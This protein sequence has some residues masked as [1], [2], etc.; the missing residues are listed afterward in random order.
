MS[1]GEKI[2][3]THVLPRN[4]ERLYQVLDLLKLTVLTKFLVQI[5]S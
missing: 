1:F 5:E 4:V 2:E 3:Q